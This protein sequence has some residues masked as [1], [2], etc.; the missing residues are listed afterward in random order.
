M[1]KFTLF[2]AVFLGFTTAMNAQ[3]CVNSSLN[4][5]C[6]IY[7]IPG[8]FTING[9]TNLLCVDSP[10]DFRVYD[11]DLST[12]IFNSNA[13]DDNLQEILGEARDVILRCYYFDFSS[14]EWLD[15]QNEEKNQLYFT[16]N[17]FN[18]DNDYEYLIYNSS[19]DLSIKSTNGTIIQ[20]LS[21]EEGY[22]WH[23]RYQFI[24]N[25]DR[26]FYLGLGALND[27]GS[28]KILVYRI[29]QSQGLTKVDMQLPISVFPTMPTREQ[30]ITVELGEGNNA[31][32]ITVVNS[33]GQ[34]V[35]RVPVDEGQREVIIPVNDLGTG[36]NVVNAR[37]DQGQ[38]SCKII[39][40]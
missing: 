11:N 37:T 26:V 1:K 24:F 36:L 8:L 12:V 5:S 10:S 14:G 32:E 18:S 31:S 40:R 25:V 7:G 13:V 29:D 20:T 28:S 3:N 9:H 22:E 23:G 16:Q 30:Q 21:P 19:W 38:G 2:L 27:N 33:L 39:V 35:K 34:V 4:L 17:L 15:R 6:K